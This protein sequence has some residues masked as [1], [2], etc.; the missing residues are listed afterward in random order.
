MGDMA[1]TVVPKSDQMNTQDL[2][3]G[4]QT[5]TIARVQVTGGDQPV[6]V[7]FHEFSPR[8]PFKPSKTVRR[9]M[10]RG[11]G[12][13]SKAYVGKRITLFADPSVTWAGEEVGGI[14][15][16]HMSGL[17]RQMRLSLPVSKNRNVT[18]L[19]DPIPDAPAPSPGVALAAA[20]TA[21]GHRTPEQM[22]E[23]CRKVVNR[24]ITHS[25]ELTPVERDQVL[26][27]LASVTTP[28]G[29]VEAAAAT[30][31][32]FVPTSTQGVYG[33]NPPGEPSDDD[34]AAAYEAE[35]DRRAAGGD[36]G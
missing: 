32:E 33:Y 15:V 13:E 11:W 8:R 4:P 18:H 19:V 36:G 5:F 28:A 16:S 7:W 21:G 20:L 23:Y 25:R 26:E 34:Q 6:S 24:P 10:I 3:T 12:D 9:L 1:E 30:P 29:S 17:E 31:G 22:L 14:R 35:Q 2:L 27:A